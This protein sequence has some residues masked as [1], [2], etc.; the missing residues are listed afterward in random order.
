[1][2]MNQLFSCM[3]LWKIIYLVLLVMFFAIIAMCK[4]SAELANQ[5]WFM[6]IAVILYFRVDYL[7]TLYLLS[8]INGPSQLLVGFLDVDLG[9]TWNRRFASLIPRRLDARINIA[10]I[11]DNY[12]HWCSCLYLTHFFLFSL[13]HLIYIHTSHFII[14]TYESFVP[15]KYWSILTFSLYLVLHCPDIPNGIRPNE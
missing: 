7:F 14:F 12:F 4:T 3:T 1:M 11:V 6:S 8:G 5:T 13:S 10:E 2:N 9:D 15:D